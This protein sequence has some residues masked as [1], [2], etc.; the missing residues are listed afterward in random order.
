MR[1]PGAIVRGRTPEGE[2]GTQG[3]PGSVNSVSQ[4]MT[5]LQRP[6]GGGS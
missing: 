4:P 2:L 3:P 1:D 6:A 5:G